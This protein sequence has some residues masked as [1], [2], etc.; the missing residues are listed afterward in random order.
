MAK[1]LKAGMVVTV[2]PGIYFIEG[3]LAD[4]KAQK[5]HEA[6]IDYSQ[7]ERWQGFGGVRNEEDWLVTEEGARRLGAAFDKS[8]AAMEGYRA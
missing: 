6:F 7:A 1:P 5:K 2:E 3:L 4:W 8:I